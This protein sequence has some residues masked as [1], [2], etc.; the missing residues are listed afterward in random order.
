M[1]KVIFA[2]LCLFLVTGCSKDDT[3][4]SNELILKNNALARVVV[5]FLGTS[6]PLNVGE[7]KTLTD[8]PNGTY[9]YETSVSIPSEAKSVAFKEHLNDT[10]K[11]TGRTKSTLYFIGALTG[12]ADNLVYEVGATFSTSNQKDTTNHLLNLF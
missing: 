1:R 3:E 4:A 9:A 6:Y 10:L 12:S 7:T 5:N 8:I 11:F 2:L